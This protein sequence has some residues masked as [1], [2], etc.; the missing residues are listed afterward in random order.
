MARFLLFLKHR[1]PF[2]WQVLEWVNSVLFQMLHAR[3]MA[4]VRAHVL[5]EIQHP[6]FPMR[7]LAEADMPALEALL[8]QQG[9]ERLR[10]FRPHGYDRKSLLRA[11]HDPAF[12]M[13]GSFA[14]ERL[15]GY[16]FLRCFWNRRCFVGRLIDEPYER[17]GIGRVMNQIMYQ[18]AWRSGFSCLSTISKHNKLVMRSHANNPAMRVLRELPNSYLLVEFV[19]PSTKDG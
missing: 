17:R 14:G 16:F 13:F 2:L 18:T 10:F 1:M 6:Y 9:E 5:E 3:R 7:E 15:V 19:Q 12:T 4:A 8:A 11:C